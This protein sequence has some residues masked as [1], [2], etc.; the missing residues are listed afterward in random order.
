MH[1]ISSRTDW[2]C[3]LKRPP[4]VV[5]LMLAL[6]GTAGA[7]GVVEFDATLKEPRMTSVAVLK[8]EAKTFVSQYREVYAA[9]P[10]MLVG[11]ASLS[12]RQFDLSWQLKREIDEG[13][14]LDEFAD[15]GIES[16]GN[17]TYRINEREHPEW[18]DL[19]TKLAAMLSFENLDTTAPSLIQGGFRP[20]DIATL[21]AYS[22]SHDP[23]AASRAAGLP[24][25]LAFVR[26][27]KKFD[28][29]RRLVPDTLVTS[30]LYQRALAV[31]E[32]NRRWSVELLK[33]LDAQ[34][35]RILLSTFL[36][37]ETITYWTPD[38]MGLAV[39][40]NLANA[41]LPNS[42]ELVIAQSKGVAP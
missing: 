9:T 20:E 1:V 24:V 38:R 23:V 31:S 28:K 30:F 41:R 12:R 6:A 25:D 29:A 40:E 7:A 13:R 18:N 11:N 2:R 14:P 8:P 3:G 37:F 17:G 42:E 16:L 10:A 5:V 4:L 35:A 34:R 15:M 32:S 19:H 36:E 33:Q 26:T 22:G 21:K 27:V 39:Q